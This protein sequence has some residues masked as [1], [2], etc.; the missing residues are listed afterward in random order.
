[1][2]GELMRP[3]L[4][5]R[6][7]RR[8]LLGSPGRRPRRAR[9]LALLVG[10]ACLGGLALMQFASA[11]AESPASAPGAGKAASP[12]AAASS[13]SS[14]SSSPS[15]AGRAASASSFAS[16]GAKSR[17]AETGHELFRSS[18]AA[19][20]GMNAEGIRG[21]APSLHGVG[22]AA[23]AFYL[24]TGR[25]PL[26]SSREQP[27]EKEPAFPKGQIEAL[28]AY[29]ASFGGPE[30]PN[31]QIAKGSVS[32]G[33]ELFALD[34]AGCHTIQAQ[35]G[36]VTGAVAPALNPA[37][38]TE[39]GEA[40]RVGPYVMPRFGP[41]DITEQDIDSIAR[42]VRTTQRPADLGGWGLG[43]LGPIPEGMV[44]WGLALVALLLIARL[45]GERMPEQSRQSAEAGA[46]SGARR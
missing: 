17:L 27:L 19:C 38:M 20:H 24:E 22:G 26:P 42:Y 3:S 28:I 11:Y 14:S 5:V 21:R 25:M 23:A 32:K 43:R 37:S 39:V 9:R 41:K 16:A 36:I 12:A 18:C 8:A 6:I 13:S 45:L 4:P 1:M 46:S 44:A 2:G 33:Q 30:V 31:V 35:G 15:S 10:A 40:I 29:V 7:L 34:C